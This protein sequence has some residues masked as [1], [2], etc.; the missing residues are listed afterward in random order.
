MDRRQFLQQVAL[1]GAVAEALP[2]QAAAQ[3]PAAPPAGETLL[4]AEFTHANV[5]WKVYEDLSLQGS[6][7]FVPAHGASYVLAK[8]AE[9]AFAETATPYLGL[10]L[11]EIGTSARDL[12]A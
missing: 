7:K 4:V 10:S 2:E 1:A 3:E 8:S 5:S 6:I 9:A 11:S 12:L